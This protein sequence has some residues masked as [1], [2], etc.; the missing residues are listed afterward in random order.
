MKVETLYA[1]IKSVPDRLRTII[2]QRGNTVNLLLLAIIAKSDVFQNKFY[3]C[4]I[5]CT[6]ITKMI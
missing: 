5:T 1:V 2:K 4:G 3:F 6:N